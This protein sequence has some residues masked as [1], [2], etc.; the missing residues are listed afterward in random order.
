MTACPQPT[1]YGADLDARTPKNWTPLSYAKAKGKYGVTHEKGIYPEDVLKV[2]S[3]VPR[4]SCA[5][6]LNVPRSITVQP[7][8]APVRSASATAGAYALRNIVARALHVQAW[9]AELSMGPRSP[10]E[11]YNPEAENFSRERGSYQ[12][13]PEHP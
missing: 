4:L 13:E 8:T 2:S 1:Q 11:S 10:R 3:A 9:C 6:Q 7:S 5:P 12:N